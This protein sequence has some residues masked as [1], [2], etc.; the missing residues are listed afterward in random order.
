MEKQSLENKAFQEIKDKLQVAVEGI[1]IVP[2]LEKRLKKEMG[3]KGY[4]K[5]KAF[6][7][8]YL[9]L[10]SEGKMKQA[11]ALENKYRGE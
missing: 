6:Q 4:A 2:E 5:Y 10:Y 9:K 7:R 1:S 11:T 3:V 8:K